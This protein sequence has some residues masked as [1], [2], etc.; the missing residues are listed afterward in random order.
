MSL[1]S[2][3]FTRQ[4]ENEVLCGDRAILEKRLAKRADLAGGVHLPLVT[5][6]QD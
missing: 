3:G 1:G 6:T 5:E 2:P 4:E